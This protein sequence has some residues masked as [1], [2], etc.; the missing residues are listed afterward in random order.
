ML[1]RDVG[2]L[3]HIS[4]LPSKYGIG[5]FGEEAFK[6]VD[7]LND[8]NITIWQILPLNVTSFGDSPYQS[9]ANYSFNYYFI[10]LDIL[11]NKGLLKEEDYIN[12]DFGDGDRVNYEKLYFNKIKVLKKAFLNFT[13]DKEFKEFIKNN[14]NSQDFAFFMTLKDL[15]N[16]KPWYEWDEKYKNYNKKIEDEIKKSEEN[17]YYFYLWTQFEFLNQYFALK[18]YANKK[19]VKIMG[20]LP[21]YLSYDSVECYKYSKLFDFND[22]KEPNKVAGC[23]PDCFSIDG[24]LWGNPLY[25]W[26][27]HKKTKYKWRNARIY[28]ALKLYDLLRIDHFRGFSGYYA[29]PFNEKTAKNGKWIKGPGFDLFK[30]K[31]N[32]PIIAEDLGYVD[33]DLIKLMKNAKYPGMKIVIQGLQDKRKNNE[34]RPRNYTRKYFSYTSTHDSDTSLQFYRNL[35]AEQKELFFKVVKEECEYL[36]VEDINDRSNEEEIIYKLIELNIAS[37]SLAAIIPIQD[38]LVLGE[39]GRMNVPSTLSTSNWSYR[40]N[41]EVFNNKKDKISKFMQENI[42]KFRKRGEKYEKN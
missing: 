12:E 21:I 34:W 1:R 31:L 37:K 6:F 29:I 9:P 33:D 10:D 7:F 23:P 5:T 24:Q 42:W 14:P 38:L 39:E 4:S 20:D 26:K 41:K 22:K 17:I 27:Y 32:L 15:N 25:N 3:L 35:K 11:K 16:G 13:F 30:D 40:I 19:N 2:I 8:S 36:N 18:K 28:N